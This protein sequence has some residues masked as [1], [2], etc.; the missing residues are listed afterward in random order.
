MSVIVWNGGSPP[1]RGA[2][3]VKSDGPS[4]N[5]GFR[6][7]YGDGWSNLASKRQWALGLGKDRSKNRNTPLKY[8]VLWASKKDAA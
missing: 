2:Y 7:W 6:Y 3:R 1:K 8:P 5:Q 4:A